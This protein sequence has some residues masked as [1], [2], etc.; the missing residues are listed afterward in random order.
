MK[1]VTYLLGDTQRVGV[2][3]RDENWIYPVDVADMLELISRMDEDKLAE[4]RALSSRCADAV[5]GAV[6][7]DAVKILAPIPVPKQDIVCLGVNYADHAVESA[8]F[9]RELLKKDTARQT[10]YFSKRVNRAVDPFGGICAHEDMT[11]QVDYEVELAVILKKD[12]KDVKSEEVQDYIFGYTIMN[13]VSARDVQT[14]HKQFYFGKSLD[15]FTPLGPCIVTADEIS[16]P[17][18][19]RIRS[20]VNGEAR[21]DSNTAYFLSTIEDVVVELTQGMTLQAGTI[22]ATG[23]PAGVGMGFTPPKF[24]QIGDVVRCE[25]EGIGILENTV[26]AKA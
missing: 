14:A 7:M 2:L 3:N 25:I 10:I 15:D 21:Q 18:Q 22:I 4:L 20:F 16:Y 1:L 12:A 24:L 13:D 26:V 11:Q 6:R 19:L 23:T 17:P 9:H 5:S 8:R